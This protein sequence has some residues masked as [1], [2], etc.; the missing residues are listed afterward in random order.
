MV[1]TSSSNIFAYTLSCYYL[2]FKILNASVFVHLCQRNDNR[3]AV[4]ASFHPASHT[5]AFSYLALAANLHCAPVTKARTVHCKAKAALWGT[6][7]VFNQGRQ[8]AGGVEGSRLMRSTTRWD[9]PPGQTRKCQACFSPRV[10]SAQNHRH[11]R[12][13]LSLWFQTIVYWMHFFPFCRAAS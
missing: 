6:R 11:S 10:Q 7:L 12:S 9:C 8:R 3:R 13:V 2:F 4:A 5:L 1:R